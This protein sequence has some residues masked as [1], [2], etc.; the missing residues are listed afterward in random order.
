M[1][2]KVLTLLLVCLAVRGAT[3]PKDRL[4]PGMPPILDSH[5]IYSA[6]HAGNLSQA[7]L[8]RIG[9]NLLTGLGTEQYGLDTQ[10]TL[11]PPAGARIVDQGSSREPR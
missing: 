9:G 10:G 2:R 5:D 11:H 6:D 3:I 8:Q 1:V 7:D 4:L